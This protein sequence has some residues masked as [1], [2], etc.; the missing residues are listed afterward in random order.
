LSS[1][2]LSTQKCDSAVMYAAKYREVRMMPP[3]VGKEKR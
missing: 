2:T 1:L 3:L